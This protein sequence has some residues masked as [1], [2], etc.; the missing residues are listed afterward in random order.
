MKNVSD[1][2][3]VFHRFECIIVSIMSTQCQC[4]IL[5]RLEPIL[6]EIIAY[7]WSYLI[8]TETIWYVYTTLVSGSVYLSVFIQMSTDFDVSID[9]TSSHQI[10]SCQIIVSSSLKC[11][12]LPGI[13]HCVIEQPRTGRLRNSK[14]WGETKQRFEWIS[15]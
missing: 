9:M 10:N 13:F 14:D 8:C 15:G 5:C 1:F 4:V 11:W 3:I 7:L 2:R 6:A 12:P